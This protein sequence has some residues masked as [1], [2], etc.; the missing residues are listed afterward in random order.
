MS[1]ATLTAAHEA[2]LGVNAARILLLLLS[3]E[4]RMGA[5]SASLETTV[6]NVTTLTRKLRRSGLV[7]VRRDPAGSGRDGRCRWASLTDEGRTAARKLY[8]A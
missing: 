6:P 8:E 7:T 2:G 3:G 4:K 1:W 5:L